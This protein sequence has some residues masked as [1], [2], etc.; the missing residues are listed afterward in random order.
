MTKE[1]L[2]K[3]LEKLEPLEA[4]ELIVEAAKRAYPDMSFQLQAYKLPTR[5]EVPTM[6]GKTI[7]ATYTKGDEQ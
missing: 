6:R 5:I 2:S 1:E 4:L 3:E 7:T